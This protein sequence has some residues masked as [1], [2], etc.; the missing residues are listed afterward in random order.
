VD[1]IF[2]G[3]EHL[4]EHWVERYQDSGGHN[5]RLDEIVTGGGGAPLYGFQGEPDT[6][7]YIQAYAAEKVQL[8]HLV[9]PALEPGGTPYHYVLVSVDGDRLQLEVIGIDWG[10]NFKPYRS[11]KTALEPPEGS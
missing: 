10:R 2:S 1:A 4:F 11:N 8:E 9:R 3:H 6:R 7:D 5:R